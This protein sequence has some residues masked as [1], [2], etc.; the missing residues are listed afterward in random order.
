MWLYSS[1]LEA[2]VV[3]VI[4][5]TDRTVISYININSLM[6]VIILLLG[7]ICGSARSMDRAAQSWDHYFVQESMDSTG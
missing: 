7:A 3:V 5:G 6:I 1:P 2:L 4:T